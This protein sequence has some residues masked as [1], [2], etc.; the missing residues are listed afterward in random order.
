M[1]SDI[2]GAIVARAVGAEVY[3]NWTDVSGL[4][5]ADP[6][7]VPDPLPVEEITY[8]EMRELAYMGADVFHDEAMF[9][10]RA[11]EIP[12]H[13]R[14]NQSA[15]GCGYADFA[16]PRAYRAHDRRGCGASQFQHAIY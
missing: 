9:P 10:V 14:N 8:R 6:R 7:M 3:E 4:L 12:I 1:G 16:E 15:R 11:A 5:M 2:T 13:I